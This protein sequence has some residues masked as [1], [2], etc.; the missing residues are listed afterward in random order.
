MQPAVVL[1]AQDVPPDIEACGERDAQVWLCRLVVDLTDSVTAG[2]I[3]RPLSRPVTV[4]L[5]LI[6]AWFVNRL[7]RIAI[8]RVERRLEQ[9]GTRDRIRRFRRRTGL[10]MLDTS[11]STPTVRRHQRAVTIGSGV[12]SFATI[13]IWVVATFMVI[14]ALGV[15]P[16]TLLT[17]AGLIGVALGFGAQNLLRDLIAGTFMILEDQFGV[18]D[19]IDTGEATGTVEHISLRA[20]RLRDVNGVVWHV[21]NGEIRRVGNMSQEWSRALLDVSV[22]YDTDIDLARDVILRTA[23]GMA[24]EPAWR[25]RILERPEVWGVEM[26]GADGISIRLV[27][28][29]RPLEQWSV[30]RELRARIKHAFDEA[31]IEIPFPQRTIWHRS[32]DPS[33]S[34]RVPE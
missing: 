30:A 33:A 23:A 21:P 12:R 14:A 34:D 2:E 32:V 31:G 22:A 9:E 17:S 3:A 6:G 18:G 19:V 27:V 4:V 26:L 15:R 5:I 1:L 20:T 24:G 28:K 11:S 16:A 7:V 25:D 10:A 8:R 29:T 13:I